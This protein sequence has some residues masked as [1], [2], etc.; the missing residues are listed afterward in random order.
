[1][2]ISNKYSNIKQ[3]AEN[4]KINYS[5]AKPFPHIVI[6]DLF[7]KSIL[8]NICNDFPDLS[9]DKSSTKFSSPSEIKLSSKRGDLQQ[10]QS[11]KSLLRFLNSHDFIE[12]LQIIT[13]IKEPLVPDPHFIGGGL[14]E[15]KRGGHLKI[16]ADFCRHPETKLDRRV[17]MLIYLNNSWEED[18]GG[19]LELWD[20]N[21]SACVQRILPI[22][23]RTVIF[24]TTDYTYHGV[25]DSLNCPDYISRKSL[26]LYYFSNGRPIEELRDEN[27]NQSTLFVNRPNEV[28][29]IKNEN[30]LL[31][32]IKDL[33]PPIFLRFLRKIKNKL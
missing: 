2:F 20:K 16:H 10:P 28:L 29:D 6:D 33:S 22:F 9:A 23:N 13:S 21:M 32:I 5:E 31:K 8:N 12:F 7:D 17:N 15:T 4:L 18:Y 3:L 27:L 24:N 25:P 30:T 11:I 14:H 1:M 26:A 19:C